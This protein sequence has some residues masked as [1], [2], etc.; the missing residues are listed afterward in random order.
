MQVVGLLSYLCSRGIWGPF[1]LAAP[2]ASLPFWASQLSGMLGAGLLLHTL[3][4]SQSSM[5]S[6]PHV[7]SGPRGPTSGFTGERSSGASLGVSRGAQQ[8]TVPNCRPYAH[9]VAQAG[10]HVHGS[11]A[12]PCV[13]PS[14]DSMCPPCTVVLC[15]LEMLVTERH[16]LLQCGFKYVVLDTSTPAHAAS[17]HASPLPSPSPHTHRGGSATVHTTLSTRTSCSGGGFLGDSAAGAGPALAMPGLPD[18]GGAFA[19]ASA[20]A[21]AAAA[22]AGM[23]PGHQ[24][25][26][27]P[28]ISGTGSIHS[29]HSCGGAGDACEEGCSACADDCY[30][31]DQNAVPHQRPAKRCAHLG[32]GGVPKPPPRVSRQQSDQLHGQQQVH[33]GHLQHQSSDTLPHGLQLSLPAVPMQLPQQLQH[34]QSHG[35]A[36]WRNSLPQLQ[37]PQQSQQGHWVLHSAVSQPLPFSACLGGQGTLSAL[38]QLLQVVREILPGHASFAMLASPQALEA[39][40]TGALL[41]LL[42]LLAPHFAH[43]IQ[44][45]FLR[46]L[47]FHLLVL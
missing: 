6:L 19:A 14:A 35:L 44:V 15:P 10:L 46:R 29:V 22:A 1:L 13:L 31:P 32:H 7:C 17:H 23:H 37:L 24:M 11:L 34:Q 5:E 3:D 4:G 2:A 38:P 9:P 39:V 45:R 21:A 47:W 18:P 26:Q 16:A 40:P 42:P 12:L 27:G 28:R 30:V 41:H 43:D 8:D 20:H 25:V 36:Q 33:A